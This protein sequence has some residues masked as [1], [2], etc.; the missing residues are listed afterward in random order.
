ICVTHSAQ[1]ASYADVHLKIEKNVV[2]GRTFTNVYPLNYEQRKHEL[3]RIVSG[4]NVTE[5]AL[6]NA[7]EM[8][9]IANS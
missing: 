8:L 5:T 3:A 4:D 7:D 9:R 1:I 6:Q 2:D